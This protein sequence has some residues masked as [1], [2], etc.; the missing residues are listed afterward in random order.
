MVRPQ[1]WQNWNLPAREKTARYSEYNSTGAGANS[2][3][4]V[5]WS[6]QLTKA[7]AKRITVK[8]VL[9]GTDGWDPLKVVVAKE[10]KTS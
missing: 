10:S 7:Q 1:C 6:K 3:A 5:S 4:R 2:K 9:S 8:T